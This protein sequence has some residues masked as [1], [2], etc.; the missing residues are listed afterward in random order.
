MPKCVPNFITFPKAVL[1]AAIDLQSGKRNG[2]IIIIIR[3]PTDTYPYTNILYAYNYCIYEQWF[4]CLQCIGQVFM[5][6]L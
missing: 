4:A 3:M 2:R 5:S 1:W 6:A